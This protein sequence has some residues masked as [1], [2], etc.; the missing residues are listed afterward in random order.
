MYLSLL[1]FDREKA[2]RVVLKVT[3]VVV[4]VVV[5]VVVLGVLKDFHY[6]KS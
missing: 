3:F 6:A 1:F 5:V 2:K 4:V